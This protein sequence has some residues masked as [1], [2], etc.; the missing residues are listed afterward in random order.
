M[1]TEMTWNEFCELYFDTA[2]KA[3]EIYLQKQKNKLGQ[4]PG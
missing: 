4:I 2:K 3:A 1:K